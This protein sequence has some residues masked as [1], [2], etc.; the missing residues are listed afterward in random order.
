[1]DARMDHLPRLNDYGQTSA[2]AGD[3]NGNGTLTCGY[4]TNEGT[5]Q[6]GSL[7]LPKDG[8]GRSIH[9]DRTRSL[10]GRWVD[11]APAKGPQRPPSDPRRSTMKWGNG[12][13]R[14]L[15]LLPRLRDEET[16]AG[17][18]GARGNSFHIQ[19][20]DGQI[21]EHETVVRTAN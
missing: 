8:N 19:R 3:I 18:F 20:R 11:F 4:I 21:S 2:A 14:L 6:S 16:T 17:R 13:S 5:S 15:R 12:Y 1:M 7:I 9:R 10:I